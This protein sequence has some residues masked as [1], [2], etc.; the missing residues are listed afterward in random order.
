MEYTQADHH[1]EYLAE[2][3]NDY[4]PL[5]LDLVFQSMRRYLGAQTLQNVVRPELRY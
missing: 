3:G 5:T 2:D 4:T 1:T